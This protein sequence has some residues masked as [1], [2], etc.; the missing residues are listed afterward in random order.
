HRVTMAAVLREDPTMA[1]VDGAVDPFSFDARARGLELAKKKIAVLPHD[2]TRPSER[3]LLSGLVDAECVRLDEE[4]MLPRS[5]SALVRALVATWHP[6]KDERE[7]A[8]GDRWLSRRLAE[9]RE[10]MAARDSSRGLDPVR[11]RELDDALDALEH[12][13][14]TPGFAASTREL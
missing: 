2:A 11:A 9:L 3:D 10:T 8:D 5:A 1:V 14:S 12:L 6:P 4:R 13:A 7:A